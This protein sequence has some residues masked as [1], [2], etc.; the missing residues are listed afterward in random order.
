M[1]SMI[2]HEQS[3]VNLLKDMVWIALK[4]RFTI[5]PYM[6]VTDNKHKE[7]PLSRG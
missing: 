6:Y 3:P 4:L 2:P 1:A 5:D 7:N